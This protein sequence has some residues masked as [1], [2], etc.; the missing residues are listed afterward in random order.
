VI[1]AID[2]AGGKLPKWILCRG[3]TT[4]CEQR[5]RAGDSISP[6]SDRAE[7]VVSHQENGW[8]DARQA[9]DSLRWLRARFC[10][11]EIVLLWAIFTSHRHEAAKALAAELG[12]R[13][14]LIPPGM[15]ADCSQ[16]G[17]RLFG[18]R[19]SRARGR[20]SAF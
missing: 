14:E 17:R 5:Q 7:L 20:L 6:P 1:A 19:K 9:C 13:L 15:T 10:S 16:L 18:N 8:T 3:T 2:A 4:K 12:I 11:G